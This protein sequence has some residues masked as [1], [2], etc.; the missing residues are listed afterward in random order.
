MAAGKSKRTPPTISDISALNWENARG[1]VHRALLWLT[2][3]LFSSLPAPH[4]ATH[5][6]LTTVVDGLAA[7]APPSAINPN[8]AAGSAGNP[9]NG[10]A[11][12]DHVHDTTA[13]DAR[14]DA[15]EASIAAVADESELL[16][17]FFSRVG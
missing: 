6:K 8:G 10:L 17:F 11:S 7:T 4:A 9:L 16:S 15:I 1:P 14:L 12:G 13:L 2:Q 5:L 3:D